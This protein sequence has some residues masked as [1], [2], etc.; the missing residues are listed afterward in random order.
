MFDVVSKILLSKQDASRP[1]LRIIVRE[2][3]ANCVIEPLLVYFTPN[4][5][6]NLLLLALTAGSGEEGE[7][8]EEEEKEEKPEKVGDIKWR[9]KQSE[10]FENKTK[11]NPSIIYASGSQT[12]KAKKA[13]RMRGAEAPEGFKTIQEVRR[14][15]PPQARGQRRGGSPPHSPAGRSSR[16]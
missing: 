6:N 8:K 9:A 2:L 1:V 15:S 7:K 11:S 12:P 10:N 3:L 4:S 14:R 5:G 16:C 13:A